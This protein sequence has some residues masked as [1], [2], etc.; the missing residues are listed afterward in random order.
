[1]KNVFNEYVCVNDPIVKR[2]YQQQLT[3]PTVLLVRPP[4]KVYSQCAAESTRGCELTRI[5][6]SFLLP[7]RFLF[8]QHVK[9]LTVTEDPYVVKQRRQAALRLFNFRH[10]KGKILYAAAIQRLTVAL[11]L[12]QNCV[13]IL[14]CTFQICVEIRVQAFQLYFFCF[15]F[16]LQLY[17]CYLVQFSIQRECSCLSLFF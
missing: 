10:T 9:Q 16:L 3:H 8:S 12:Q 17:F 6:S 4:A 2:G 5:N 11:L 14:V 13:S 7:T 15:C 1:M